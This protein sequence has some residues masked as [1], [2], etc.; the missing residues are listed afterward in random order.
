MNSRPSAYSFAVRPLAL[1]SRTRSDHLVSVSIMRASC[2]GAPT[3]HRTGLTQAIL[4]WPRSSTASTSRKLDPPHV[5][6]RL[7][8]R[9]AGSS[10]ALVATWSGD[11]E[12]R[13][14][15]FDAIGLELGALW[16]R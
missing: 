16:A 10:L 4:A 7:R 6:R 14:E 13:A 11:R 15:P 5:T 12:V 1:H 3:F 9:W 8:P 2:G